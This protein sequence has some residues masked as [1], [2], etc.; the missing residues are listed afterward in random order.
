MDNQT[1]LTYNACSEQLATL[2]ATLSPLKIYELIS[3]YFVKNGI[4]ADIGCGIGRD[5]AWM[6]EHGF[7]AIGIDASIGMLKQARARYPNV[8]F[9]QDSL[10]LLAKQKDNYYANILCSAVIM[11]LP[12]DQIGLAAINLVRIVAIDGSIVVSYR[13]TSGFDSRENGKLYTP[14]HESNMINLFLEAG[15]S[16]VCIETD[17]EESRDLTW[18]NLVFKKLPH[19]AV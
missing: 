8:N 3:K 1:I 13:G 18:V 14:I 10:P 9:S 7:A 2:H 16:L 12:V 4:T 19:P 11:H 5:S 17:L 6:I 15:A